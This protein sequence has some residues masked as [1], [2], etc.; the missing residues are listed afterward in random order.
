MRYLIVA[1]K[2]LAPALVPELGSVPC[3]VDDIGEHHGGQHSVGRVLVP[4][5]GQELL[6][7]ADDRLV[8][9]DPRNMVDAIEVDQSRT[10]EPCGEIAPQLDG[11]RIVS[12][13]QD[14]RRNPDT[15]DDV[16]H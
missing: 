11:Y 2:Q 1:F 5:S 8:V 12:A 10:L 15:S 7:L 16:R 3:G 4:L 9:A 13:M 6:R 14:E